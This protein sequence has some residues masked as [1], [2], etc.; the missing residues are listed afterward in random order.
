M[1][2]K[3]FSAPRFTVLALGLGLASSAWAL[4]QTLP[5]L[6]VGADS[7]SNLN[8]FVQP[9][10]PALSGGGRDQSLQFG[11]VVFGSTGPD[12]LIGRLGVDVLVGSAGGDVLI[13]GTEHFNPLN[14]DRA[15]GGDGN[16]AFLWAP[17]DGSDFFDGGPGLDAVVFGLM[18]EVNDAGEV[19][20]GVSNDQLAGNVFLD[21]ITGL[22]SMNIINSPGFCQII[23]DSSTPNAAAELD[24]LNIDHLAQFVIRGL[25]DSFEAGTQTED[26]GL[27]VS[28]HLKDVE[29]VVCATREGGALEVLD[30]R[31]SPPTVVDR[32]AVPIPQLSAILR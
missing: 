26:N 32:A 17:G 11:D 20:F 7:N 5:N 30:L 27:R 16:D 23:D 18:G 9:Q 1:Q 15:F 13:G 29:F 22:P 28:L 14:R 12:V 10:D 31:T 3:A 4:T 6:F 8:P 19:F 25:A 21:N 2:I 24:A